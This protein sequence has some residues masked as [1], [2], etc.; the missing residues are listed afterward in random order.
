MS[1]EPCP[2]CG[3]APG[4]ACHTPLG[5]MLSRPHIRR[6]VPDDIEDEPRIDTDWPADCEQ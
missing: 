3:A 5:Y 1:R 6:D 2:V 4:V